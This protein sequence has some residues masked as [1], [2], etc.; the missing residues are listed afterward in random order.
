MKFLR[1]TDYWK[2][3][4]F[5]WSLR[6]WMYFY[7]LP[8][9]L[10]ETR[11]G[12]NKLKCGVEEIPLFRRPYWLKYGMSCITADFSAGFHWRSCFSGER[13]WKSSL[14]ISQRK[15]WSY[16]ILPH[17]VFVKE[18]DIPFVSCFCRL[19]WLKWPPLGP[20][21]KSLTGPSKCVEVQVFPRITL[22]LTCE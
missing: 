13:L 14:V 20:S 15:Y 21:A 7:Q 4:N 1:E 17:G 3:L 6:W 12:T 2:L 9:T 18:K 10:S 22:W 19:Q 8:E 5:F 16:Q 11:Q